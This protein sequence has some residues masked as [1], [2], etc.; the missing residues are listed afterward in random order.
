MEH[1]YEAKYCLRGNFCYSNSFFVYND[2]SNDNIV[3]DFQ[4][5]AA[6]STL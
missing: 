3:E 4:L 6:L 2:L 5:I 1:K